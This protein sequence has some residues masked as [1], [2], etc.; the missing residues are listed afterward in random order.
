MSE[1]EFLRNQLV[2]LSSENLPFDLSICYVYGLNGDCGVNCPKFKDN[3]CEIY[4]EV[5]ERVKSGKYD[6]N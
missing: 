4:N 1:E 6:R 3:T 2:S 5:L